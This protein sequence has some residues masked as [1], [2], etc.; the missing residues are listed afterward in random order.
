MDRLSIP[1]E[2]ENDLVSARLQGHDLAKEI[3]FGAFDRTL[4]STTIS[5]LARN[6]LQY[7]TTGTIEAEMVSD[8]S[9]KGIRVR[10]VDEGPGIDDLETAQREGYSTGGGLGM[11]LSGSQ[12]LMDGF[13]ID[14]K[15]GKGTTVEVLKWL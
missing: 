12:R 1:I 4:I 2:N 15:P 9:R 14:S 5:E 10:A 11:G 13:S 6:I 3:G 8:A 7:A